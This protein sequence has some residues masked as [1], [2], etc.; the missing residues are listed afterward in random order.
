MARRDCIIDCAN[1]DSGK[2]KNLYPKH[3]KD[4]EQ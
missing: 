1:D 4:G 2:T 3:N